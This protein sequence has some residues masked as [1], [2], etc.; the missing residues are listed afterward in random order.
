MKSFIQQT[1]VAPY[2]VLDILQVAEDRVIKT[3]YV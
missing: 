3:R 2:Y 1:F